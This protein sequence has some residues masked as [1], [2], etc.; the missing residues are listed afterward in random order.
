M[1]ILVAEYNGK[2][3]ICIP[4][5]F[6]Y[7]SLA[8][9]ACGA[10]ALA[11]LSGCQ[12]ETR[13]NILLL[14]SDNQSWNHVG[15]YGD[16]VVRTPNIDAIASQ[17]VRFTNAFC[18]APSST[19]A[20]AALL[21]GQDIW[22]LEEGANLHGTLPAKYVT[23][24]DRLENAG[25]FCG[26]TGKGWGP[27]NFKAAGRTRNPGGDNFEGFADFLSNAPKGKP[28]HFWFSSKEPHRPFS[29]GTSYHSLIQN[30]E[31]PPYLPDN[32]EVRK[33]ICDYYA[34]IERFDNEVGEII[35]LLKAS[36]QYN[37]T[38]IV[39]CSDN[40]WQ[41]PRGLANLYDSGTKIPL[42]ISYP[43]KF[44]PAVSEAFVNLN[45][46]T[47]TFL[48]LAGIA[49][50][51]DMTA[52]SLIPVLNGGE[53][54]HDFVVMARERHAYVRKDGLGYP[55]RA[56]RTKDYLYIRN[57]E[58]DRWPAGDPPLFGDV[59]AHMLHY[60]SLAKVYLLAHQE[61]PDIKPLFDLS[62]S[63]RP[64]EELYDL[65]SDPYQM[66]NIV[67]QEQYAQ[68]RKNMVN[69]LDNYLL[70]NG[71]P[72]TSGTETIWD[73][74]E[75]YMDRDKNPRPGEDAIKLLKLEEEYKY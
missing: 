11:S 59:D 29:E 55:G 53:A 30:I 6:T 74:A 32:E 1:S 67:N 28:W 15:C 54:T 62:F 20:R 51:E 37:N 47:P 73:Q 7:K 46:I 56:I 10:V 45:D 72:R 19:P 58:P 71:D 50:P 66:N 4:M 21:T 69:L 18:A 38:I 23:Y 48:E 49:K 42:I 17:G 9:M 34:A 16:N 25:Y 24:P 12:K 68:Q 8:Q 57:Y 43:E 3:L 35:K 14:M 39:V 52:N 31:V 65:K 13:P 27:G 63:K 26:I 44:K 2:P 64:A 70:K 75:Y 61:N 60:K 5:D 36:G 22:R 41:M 40:G 33:D